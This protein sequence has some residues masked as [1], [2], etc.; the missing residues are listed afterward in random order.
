MSCRAK[1]VPV[2]SA[3]CSVKHERTQLLHHLFI[4]ER[5]PLGRQRGQEEWVAMT[6]VKTR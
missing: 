3:T 4:D 2:A 1:S 6:N 5:M